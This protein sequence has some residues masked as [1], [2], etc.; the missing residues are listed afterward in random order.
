MKHKHA[1]VLPDLNNDSGNVHIGLAQAIEQ[2]RTELDAV[3]HGNPTNS[4]LRFRLGE[5]TMEFAVEF[6]LEGGIETG[7]K[8]WVV[9]V[10]A[11]G[12]VSRTK[13]NTVTVTMT[14]H[15]IGLDG[16]MHDVEVSGEVKSLPPVPRPLDP[17][18]SREP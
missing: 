12:S 15:K 7:F 14:P 10:G 17:S 11:S 4:D 6:A 9:N 5:V 1:P 18:P 16:K 3:R 2:V 8:L 13:T